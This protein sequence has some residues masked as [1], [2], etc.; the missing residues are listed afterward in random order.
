LLRNALTN[1]G[2]GFAANANVLHFL[3]NNDVSFF[4]TYHGVS[5]T[6]MVAAL[7]FTLNG[8][9][10]VYNGDEIGATG[11]PYNMESI[12]YP[13]FPLDHN[14]PN[15]FFQLYQKLIKYRKTMPALFG[16]NYAEITVSPASYIFGFRRWQNDQNVFTVL[17]MGSASTS[18]NISL[19]VN[20]LNL[21]TNKTYYLTDLL[22]GQIISGRLPQLASVA[23][24]MDAF[25]AKIFYLADSV[26]VTSA[27]E[28]IVEN[29]P[30]EFKLNQ[31]YPNPF[32]PSTTIS[33]NIP[34][35]GNV[36]LKVYDILGREV[37]ILFNGPQQSGEHL[38]KFNSSGLSSGI[39]IYRINYNGSSLSRK[40]IVLK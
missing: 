19:P 3:D 24:S 25:S 33:Y 2:L 16:N 34:K 9:P 21:D 17:N 11:F 32:N 35:S 7:E 22:S 29:V 40:M 36:E 5:R 14:D 23:T 15:A 10:L 6:K 8:T 31:N 4:N 37:A 13:G 1:N 18:V 30:S 20:Q 27:D 12:F 28:R 26:F 38:V 39:Y